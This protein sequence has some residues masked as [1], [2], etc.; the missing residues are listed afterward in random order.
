MT[1]GESSS[2]PL[3]SVTAATE[4]SRSL[5]AGLKESDSDSWDRLVSLYSPLIYYWCQRMDLPTQEMPD[6]FQEVFHSVARNIQK[7]NREQAGG[8]FRGWLRTVTRNKVHDYYRKIG[9]EPRPTG[10]TEAKNRFEQIPAFESEPGQADCDNQASEQI[11]FQDLYG[12]ALAEIRPHFQEQ[13]W[14]AF[15]IVVIEG[16]T[17]GDAANELSMQP[18]TVRVAKSRV[19]HRLRQELGDIVD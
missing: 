13:T 10:G 15:W 6:V 3:N 11:V 9:R 1:T 16:R 7:F 12:R 18:G 14:Q 4:T 19:L 17:A 8:T 2:R 5:L